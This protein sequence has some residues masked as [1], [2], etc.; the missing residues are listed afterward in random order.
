MGR[1]KGEKNINSKNKNFCADK[2]IKISCFIILYLVYK[3]I[4]GLNLFSSKTILNNFIGEAG[5]EADIMASFIY[6]P[7]LFLCE[8]VVV[9][10]ITCF[11]F[12]VYEKA[13]G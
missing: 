6:M 8:L 5:F 10:L 13:R 12:W 11:I 9:Y 2:K 7:L 3:I 4:L 1:E